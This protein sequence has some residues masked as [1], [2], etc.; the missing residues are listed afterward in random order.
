MI[1][2]AEHITKLPKRLNPASVY[3]VGD[4]V[5]ITS[6][7]GDC[8]LHILKLNIL[9]NYKLMYVMNMPAECKSGVFYVIMGSDTPCVTWVAEGK[10][11]VRYGVVTSTEETNEQEQR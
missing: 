5:V 9:I 7:L 2:T 3:K 1:T 11:N 10:Q 4:G 8:Y 6:W